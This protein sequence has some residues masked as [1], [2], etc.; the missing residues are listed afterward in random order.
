MENSTAAPIAKGLTAQQWVEML[1]TDKAK[2]AKKALNYLDGQQEAELEKLLS[3]PN[4]GRRGWKSRGIIARTRNLTKM[5]VEKS[6]QLFKDKAPI[7]EVYPEGADTYDETDTKV[8]MDEMYKT[9]WQEFF[10][11]VDQVVRLLKT[12]IVLMQYNQE[13]DRI[14]LEVLHR[15]NCAVMVNPVSRSID[16]LIYITSESGGIATYRI[17]TNDMFIDLMEQKSGGKSQIVITDQNPNTYGVVPAC[18]FYDT[19]VPRSG[20]W[21]EASMELVGINELVNLH[22]TDSEYAIS[23]A[24]LPTLFM[25]DCEVTGNN[26]TMELV[27]DSNSPLPHQAPTEQVH[28][29]GPSRAIMLASN[30]QG[31]PS[32]QYLS[33]SINIEPLDKVVDN[34]I[35]SYA[36]DWSVRVK[37]AGEG[38]A[39]SGFQLVVEELPNLDLRKMRQR[40]FEAGFKRFYR[41][42]RSVVS[43]AKGVSLNPTAELFVQFGEPVL[44]TDT[45]VQEEVWSVRI[46]EKRATVI[47][48]LMETKGM[49]RDEAE[50]KWA[51]IKAFDE[52]QKVVSPIVEP[53]VEPTEDVVLEDVQDVVPPQGE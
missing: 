29:G 25:I 11:N 9:E 3:D 45:K 1:Q 33:P 27:Q 14:E 38:Q 23:W 15:G 5:I 30:G 19:S 51:E 4:K 52:A 8:F 49:T 31:T 2:N 44:P 20:F 16:A 12:A 17:I 26:T 37:A 47:D 46:N 22:I 6:G 41:V 10:I 39:T 50:E 42:F 34:W 32:V 13:D 21:N 7:F 43:V 18:V 40:M 36:A 48:Y 53:V 28:T 35:K 24:K